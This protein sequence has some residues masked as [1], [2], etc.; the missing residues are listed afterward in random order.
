MRTYDKLFPQVERMEIFMVNARVGKNCIFGKNI[1]VGKGVTIGHNCIIEDNVVIGDEVY[2]DSNTIIRGNVYLGDNAFI[3][4]N[5]IL[6]EYGMEFCSE[7]RREIRT[8]TIGKKALVRSG[9]IIYAGSEIGDEFQT[10]HNVT[11]REKCKIGSHVSIGTLSDV[12]GNCRIGNYVR[13]HSNVHIGQL[14]QIDDFVWIFPY[15]VLTNDPTPPSEQFLGVHLKSFSVIATGAIILPG[16][17][18]NHDSLVAAGAIVTKNVAPFA[19]VGGNPAKMISDVRNIKNKT[20]GKPVYPWRYQFKR[21]MPWE[22]SDFETW[23]RSLNIEERENYNI[24]T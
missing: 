4:S 10:G 13:M 12:Q 1:T 6:G 21:Y 2:I 14:S 17:E 3:A 11:I 16:V 19:V 24:N 20:T 8:L 22:D 5:C 15:V 9:T 18:I 7:R 23:Y